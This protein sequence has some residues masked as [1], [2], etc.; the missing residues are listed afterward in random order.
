MFRQMRATRRKSKLPGHCVYDITDI[1]EDELEVIRYA[2]H[3][4]TLEDNEQK[5]HPP[6]VSEFNEDAVKTVR[7]IHDLVHDVKTRD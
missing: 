1:T 4:L 5:T 3:F 7:S 6:F 2:L